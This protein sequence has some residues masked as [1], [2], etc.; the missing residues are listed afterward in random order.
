MT[1]VFAATAQKDLN[2]LATNSWTAAYAE[3]AGLTNV[4]TLAPSSV[5][6]PSEYELTIFDMKKIQNAEILIYAGYEVAVAQMKKM[7][8]LEAQKYFQIETGYT[9]ESLTRA[10]RKIANRANTNDVAEQSIKQIGDFFSLAR[11]YIEQNGLKGKPV[12][13]H[14]FQKDFAKDLGLEPVAIIGPAPLEVYQ[15]V[16]LAQMKEAVMIIDNIHNPVSKP[17]SEILSGIPVVELIN[18]PG[19]EGT[20]SLH[21]VLEY[22]L[23]QIVGAIK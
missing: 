23:S 19:P 1:I 15:I 8:I 20:A 21:S 9:E 11:N 10:I 7:L 6:H 13:V 3:A 14:F 18:F 17:L 5:L 4:K 2:T 12:I 22:N 16:E